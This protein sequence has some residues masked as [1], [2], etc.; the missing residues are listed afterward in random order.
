MNNLLKKSINNIVFNCGDLKQG[1]SV[2]ILY[3]KSSISVKN[4]FEIFLKNKQI[5]YHSI[6]QKLSNFHGQEPSDSVYRY[7]IKYSLII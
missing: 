7:S 1:E 6:K 2:F 4:L 5:K 3:D